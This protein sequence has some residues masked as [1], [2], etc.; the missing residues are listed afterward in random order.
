MHILIFIVFLT[1]QRFIHYIY[2]TF[3]ITSCGEWNRELLCSVFF[4]VCAGIAF[5]I[6][7]Y[8]IVFYDRRQKGYHHLIQCSTS[9]PFVQHLNC[10]LFRSWN[11]G[12]TKRCRLSWLTNSALIFEPKCARR[13][14]GC[15][16]SAN[17]YSYSCAHGAQINF[18]DLTPYLTYA[19]T[20][21]ERY[22]NQKMLYW[23]P[24]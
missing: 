14:R 2:F 22:W 3:A 8:F 6:F 16:V 19:I 7:N 5:L 11:Q 13:G 15:R 12:V 10:N 4:A 21:M 24:L 17:E 23:L 20:C 1:T 9:S 18:G